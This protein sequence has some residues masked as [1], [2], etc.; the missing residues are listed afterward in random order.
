MFNFRAGSLKRLAIKSLGN[1]QVTLPLHPKSTLH[2]GMTFLRWVTRLR[3]MIPPRSYTCLKPSSVRRISTVT[4]RES[5]NNILES[6]RHFNCHADR[7]WEVVMLPLPALRFDGLTVVVCTP[8]F[9]DA[10]PGDAVTTVACVC[11]FP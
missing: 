10:G 8:H 4:G 7:R 1:F 5:S 6:A 9:A 11:C 2:R 3:W